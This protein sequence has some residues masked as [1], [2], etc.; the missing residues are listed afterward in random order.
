MQ[1]PLPSHRP[2][3]WFPTQAAIHAPSGVPAATAKQEPWCPVTLHDMQSAQL[4][5][6]QQVPSTQFPLAQSPATVQTCPVAR[7]Q[8]LS[9]AQL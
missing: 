6:E 9:A 4:V 3:T 5:D 1:E 8:V 2:P 7:L